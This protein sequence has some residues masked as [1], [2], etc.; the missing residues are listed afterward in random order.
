[1]AATLSHGARRTLPARRCPAPAGETSQ[2]GEDDGHA[3]LR[4]WREDE[5]DGG[6]GERGGE[7][8]AAAHLRRQQGE[9]ERGEGRVQAERARIVEQAA[10]ERAQDGA[11]L[12]RNVERDAG[13]DHDAAVDCPSPRLATATTRRSQAVP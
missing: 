6:S 13:A 8:P 12:P 9:E 1:M 11:C 10:A 4:E 2:R 5:R 7:G 3:C